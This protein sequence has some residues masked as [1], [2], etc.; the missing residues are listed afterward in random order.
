MKSMSYEEYCSQISSPHPKEQEKGHQLA[1][2]Q[3]ILIALDRQEKRGLSWDDLEMEGLAPLDFLT[4]IVDEK[5]RA[6]LMVMAQPQEKLLRGY[7]LAPS[8]KARELDA[9]C[10]KWLSRQPGRN[11]REKMANTKR[12]KTV[13]REHSLDTGENRLALAY[14]KEMEGRLRFCALHRTLTPQEG[15]FLRKI[16]TLIKEGEWHEVKPWN[17]L[18]PNNTLLSHPQYSQIWQGWLSLGRLDAEIHTLCQNLDHYLLLWIEGELLYRLKQECHCPQQR[19]H[20]SR[21]QGV[22]DSE[23]YCYD[24]NY[25]LVELTREDTGIFLKKGK[26]STSLLIAEQR[27]TLK[28][29][30]AESLWFSHEEI[31][32]YVDKMLQPLQLKSRTAFQDFGFVAQSPH[33]MVDLFELHPSIKERGAELCPLGQR[34]LV[35]HHAGEPLDCGQS[36]ALLLTDEVETNTMLSSITSPQGENQEKNRNLAQQLKGY[37]PT[38]SLT[39]LSP[40][41]VGDF[42]KSNLQNHLDRYFPKLEFFP[43]SLGLAHWDHQARAITNPNW[44]EIVVVADLLGSELTLTPLKPLKEVGFANHDWEDSTLESYVAKGLVWERHPTLTYPIDL[45]PWLEGLTQDGAP[46]PQKLLDLFGIEGLPSLEGL[47]LVSQDKGCYH[48]SPK[49]VKKLKSIKLPIQKYLTQ[50]RASYAPLISDQKVR[51][52]TACPYLQTQQNIC[53]TRREQMEGANT[54]HQLQEKLTD[55]P[56]DLTLWRD[57]LPQLTLILNGADHHLIKKDSFE[58]TPK[59]GKSYEIPINDVH[60]VLEA[61]RDIWRF[62]VKKE[63]SDK[64]YKAVVKRP[65]SCQGRLACTLQLNYT[66]GAPEAY[67]LTFHTPSLERP[68]QVIW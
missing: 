15:R 29:E 32:D 59:I 19:L 12:I 24:G 37:L 65:Q 1:Q 53:Y 51:V 56:V 50:F 68:L 34:I 23:F 67:R 61:D 46:Q 66:Y 38:R 43:K 27:V 8:Y 64:V 55:L 16:R 26:K 30:R 42:E 49:L 3:K 14:W 35:Q 7:H 60:V 11:K 63:A 20:F 31:L 48:I 25:E 62:D 18:P 10:L 39:V 36:T 17:H 45:Q 2:I 47:P 9:N 4:E 52:I 57:T 6:S 58:I 28:G 22:F 44:D 5:E 54:F 40:D 41:G 33:L 21:E 13:K